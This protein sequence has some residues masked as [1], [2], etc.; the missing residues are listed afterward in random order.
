MVKFRKGDEIIRRG[1]VSD[2]QEDLIRVVWCDVSGAM[3]YN[4]REYEKSFEI[5]LKGIGVQP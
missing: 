5:V 4:I 1:I 2:V 3:W